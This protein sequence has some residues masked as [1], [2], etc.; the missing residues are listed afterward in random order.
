MA[1]EEKNKFEEGEDKVF[2]DRLKLAARVLDE[3]DNLIN[4]MTAIRTK[5]NQGFIERRNVKDQ[6]KYHFAWLSLHRL[7]S[8][9]EFNKIKELKRK[10]K[11][12]ETSEK[13][14]KLQEIMKRYKNPVEDVIEEKNKYMVNCIINNA[15]QEEVKKAT[16]EWKEAEKNT[17]KNIGFSDLELA[18]ELIREMVSLAGY[19]L[20][21]FKDKSGDLFDEE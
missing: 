18:E 13:I 14:K 16:D 17:K 2:L 9:L 1:E 12:G 7:Y 11:K 19:H 20:D 15:P 21:T 6:E 4:L 3:E 10:H 8:M 5:I